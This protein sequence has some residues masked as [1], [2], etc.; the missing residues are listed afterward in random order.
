[1]SKVRVYEV[2]KQLNMDQKTLVAIFQSMGIGDVRNHMSA[3]E[4]DV[5]ERVKRHLERQKAPEVVEERVRSDGRVVKRRARPN[6][7]EAGGHFEP[8]SVPAARPSGS[9]R[10]TDAGSA[11]GVPTSSPSQAGY[12][13]P[14]HVPEAPSSAPVRRKAPPPAPS[15]TSSTAHG[16]PAPAPSSRSHEPGPPPGGRA[17][18]RLAPPAVEAARVHPA[19]MTGASSNGGAVTAE[20]SRPAAD[21]AA[22]PAP[23][24]STP[25]PSRSRASKQ[26]AASAGAA[27]PVMEMFE[28]LPSR[29]RSDVAHG[30]EAPV[31]HTAEASISMEALAPRRARAFR[32]GAPPRSRSR[33]PCRRPVRPSS[34]RR[35]RSSPRS[36]PGPRRPRRWRRRLR[37]RRR[38]RS[39]RTRTP[40]ASRRG[41]PTSA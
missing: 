18:L 13:S 22:A 1:M 19:S 36:S 2:A 39:P 8:G 28:P 6:E 15:S 40:R 24:A 16:G 4:S 9:G 31:P 26:A 17:V 12:A 34:R 30:R 5:V 11:R 10:E 27:P 38:V 21:I 35:S 37:R 32:R 3:V 25:K 7:G 23:A 29:S 14:H 33:R 20:P 41:L